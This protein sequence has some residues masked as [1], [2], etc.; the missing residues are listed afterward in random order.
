MLIALHGLF[1]SVTAAWMA[2]RIADHE[3]RLIAEVDADARTGRHGM[4]IAH[5]DHRLVFVPILARVGAID[6][7][8]TEVR[9]VSAGRPN[10]VLNASA[11]GG[12]MFE[13]STTAIHP[14]P[15]PSMFRF[16]SGVSS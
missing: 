6:Q 12:S 16:K 3:V 5:I 4:R 7:H 14:L 1:F 15:L 2:S 10:W 9:I 11:A 13:S 8:R